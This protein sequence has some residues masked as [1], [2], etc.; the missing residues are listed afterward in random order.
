MLEFIEVPHGP[1]FPHACVACTGTAGPL[2]DTHREL[3]A[4]GR[5]YVC[6]ACIKRLATVSG[7]VAGKDLDAVAAALEKLSVA[8]RDLAETQRRLAAADAELTATRERADQL[9]VQSEQQSGR[10]DQLEQAIAAKAAADLALVT[11]D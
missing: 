9:E 3:H 2:L 10:I 7:L 1:I 8:E 11:R 5:V 6:V 4:Y